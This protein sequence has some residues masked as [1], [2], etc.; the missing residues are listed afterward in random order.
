MSTA[1]V[2]RKFVSVAEGATFGGISIRTIQKLISSGKLAVF[3]VGRRRLIDLQS[4][5]TLIRH[6]ETPAP[7]NTP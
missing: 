3:S 6:G 5:E 7:E 1:T 2:A 4:L